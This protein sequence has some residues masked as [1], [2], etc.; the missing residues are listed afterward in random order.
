MT[1]TQKIWMW[2]FIA[3][4]TIPE[5]LWSPVG[6]FIYSFFKPLKNGYSQLLRNNFLF[7]YR[8]E[9]LLKFIILIQS[10]AVVSFLIFLFKN[11][12]I[13]KSKI[14]FWI[15]LTISLLVCLITLF[16]FYLVFIFNP[17][18]VL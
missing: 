9:N 10:I 2:I 1:K 3:M 5:I 6:N 4:F 14:I 7:D 12:N 11:K 17:E 18:L 16:V 13:K 15:I 8:Y